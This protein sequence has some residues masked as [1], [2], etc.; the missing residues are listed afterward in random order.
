WSLERMAVAFGLPTIGGKD[1]YDWG[2]GILLSNQ[3]NDGGWKGEYGDY[4]ADTCFALLFLRRAD[5]AKDLSASLKNKV[6]DTAELRADPNR[7]KGRDSIKPI[8][9]PFDDVSGSSN[10]QA[11]SRPT[12]KRRTTERSRPAESTARVEPD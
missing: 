10:D 7:F 11:K 1:W 8:K 5:L 3:A 4:G 9:S 6:K 12:E 2:A